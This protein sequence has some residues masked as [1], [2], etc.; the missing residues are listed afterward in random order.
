MIIAVH[1]P[2]FAGGAAATAAR[3]MIM[4]TH[5]RRRGGRRRPRSS[6]CA[7]T[8]PVPLIAAKRMG[9][10][11]T[12]NGT[13]R[14]Q[15]CTEPP[16]GRAN[17]A[18]RADKPTSPL[19]RRRRANDRGGDRRWP[20][21]SAGWVVGWQLG[22]PVFWLCRCH[23]GGVWRVG[24]PPAARF[25]WPRV[26]ASS[27]RP[28]WLLFVVAGGLGLDPR[29]R[30]QGRGSYQGDGASLGTPRAPRPTSPSAR[31]PVAGPSAAVATVSRR[32]WGCGQQ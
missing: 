25:S 30:G 16:T 26:R 11:G 32:L 7:Q 10:R 19:A 28:L 8:R 5:G 23:V 6:R 20:V 31:R 4:E 13:P 27:P 24:R 21:H 9:S 1:S 22:W 17:P 12:A 15:R 3:S 2:P 29:T 18:G 14:G